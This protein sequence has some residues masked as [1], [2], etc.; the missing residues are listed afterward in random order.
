MTAPHLDLLRGGSPHLALSEAPAAVR[1]WVEQVLGSPVVTAASQ[2]GGFSP[3]VAARV[4]CADGTRAFVKA[5]GPE[6]NPHTPA[7]V[8]TEIEV[9]AHLPPT[10][11]RPAV[12]GSYDD[13][14]WVGLLLE[15]VDGALPALPWRRP[16]LDRVLQA[17]LELARLLPPTTWPSAPRAQDA[18]ADDLAAWSEMAAGGAPATGDPWAVHHLDRLVGLTA[19]ALVG[20]GTD[21][22]LCHV[23][24]RSDNVLVGA[25]RVT[26][27]DWNWAATGPA[28][29]DAAL[30]LLEV[31]T[32]GG[33][34]VEDVVA[35][36]PLLRDVEPGLFTALVAAAAGMLG[37]AR[38]RPP[39]PGLP[40]I[41]AFRG[42]YADALLAWTR[43]RTGW[44]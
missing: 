34:D 9:L 17:Q 33:I 1:T 27:V 16:E 30:L 39:P 15:E 44:R 36:H 22:V 20:L 18:L 8:R 41:R 11:L 37:R 29:L 7:L 5:V 35:E 28:W 2:T 3:G 40:R 19:E 24:L 6:L 23:D 38:L 21:E 31:R 32:A 14:A 26:F 13:G 10:P 12:L 43:E 42:A 25:H 4:R